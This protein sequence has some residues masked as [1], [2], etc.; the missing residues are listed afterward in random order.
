MGYST[1]DDFKY[2]GRKKDNLKSIT[3]SLG[4]NAKL[5]D[6]LPNFRTEDYKS[7][8]EDYKL[9]DTDIPTIS[10]KSIKSETRIKMD[11][12][13]NITKSRKEMKEIPKS[14]NNN[15]I[16]KSYKQIA[17]YLNDHKFSKKEQKEVPIFTS[18]TKST[19]IIRD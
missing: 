11:F 15:N 8:I 2:E 14:P 13:D 1:F 10:L 19:K 6:L 16:I 4:S 17:E 7:K 9:K 12:D 3:K 5:N 18:N